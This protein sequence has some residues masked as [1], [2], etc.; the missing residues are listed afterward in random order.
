MLAVRVVLTEAPPTLVFDEVD[1]GIGGEAGIAVGRLLATLGCAPPGA[2]RHAPRAGGGVRRHPGRGGEGRGA[3]VDE[4]ATGS[5]RT[6]ATCAIV[7]GDERVAELSRMLAG[8]GDSSHAR[9]HAGRAA[10]HGRHRRSARSCSA[11]T[12]L[13][14]PA[15]K[16]PADASVRPRRKV[17][18]R[19]K[20][21]IRRL[22]P[23]RDRGDRPR[24]LDRVAAD[25]LIE[26]GV[27]AVV[28]ARAVDL[29]P[30]PERR[31]DPRRAGRDPAARRRRRRRP[32]PGPRGRHRCASSTARSGATASSSPRARSSPSPRSKRRWRRRAPASAASSSGSPTTRSSTCGARRGSR[33][34]R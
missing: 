15:V 3:E 26:A 31:S 33:S 11:M 12:A 4:R 20:D 6:V 25:G 23:G 30:L 21:L 18:R 22:E 9:R 28:N 16:T 8:V 10:R 13:K 5:E 1:A 19:T 14:P 17:D 27:A 29:G 2:V 32:R 24:D 7:D 34:S